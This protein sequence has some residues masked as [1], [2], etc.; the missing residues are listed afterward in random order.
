MS[1]IVIEGGFRTFVAGAKSLA[2]LA[3]AVIASVKQ[4]NLNLQELRAEC[5]SLLHVRN[6]INRL[7]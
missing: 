1:T 5:G 4:Q 2:E 3:K 6:I 7:R